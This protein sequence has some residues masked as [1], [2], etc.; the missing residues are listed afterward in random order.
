MLIIK[1]FVIV[2]IAL[3]F[4]SAQAA[5]IER[6]LPFISYVSFES[7]DPL[8]NTPIP[9]E[10]RSISAQL[11][12]PKN[13]A[14][15]DVKCPAVVIVHGSNAIDTRGMFYAKAFNRAGFATLEI[16]LFAARGWLGGVKGRIN[17]PAEI[18]ASLAD[19]YGALAFLSEQVNIDPDRIAIMGF[20]LG[21][22]HSMFTATQQYTNLMTG[23][24]QKFTA[25]IAHY[26]I[27]WLYNN[28]PGAEFQNFTGSPVLI[29]V[30]E[31]DGY[32]NADTCP[33]LVQSLSD[34]AQ[35]FI[36][37]NVYKN[38]THAWDDF[39]PKTSVF[40]PF[41]CFGQGCEVMI[42]PN[43]RV[44]YRA[45]NRAIRFLKEAFAE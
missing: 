29:Q 1:F 31:L 33:N 7:A 26:P 13:C 45:R 30:G 32:H 44:A 9:F 21:G 16:D 2:F 38:T 23:G 3:T 17:T 5:R 18:A 14:E 36:S 35:E 37:V 41:A 19:S 42:K 10:K 43:R 22:I 15:Q 28:L 24:L 40:D 27:C 6:N 20:S 12:V 11:R 39:Q 25:H 34:E 8:I 4:S